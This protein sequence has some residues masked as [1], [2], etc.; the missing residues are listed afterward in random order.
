MTVSGLSRIPYGKEIKIKWWGNPTTKGDKIKKR[1]NHYLPVQTLIEQPFYQYN[2]PADYCQSKDV[3]YDSNNQ[4]LQCAKNRYHGLDCISNA[5]KT[6]VVQSGCIT[7]GHNTK[8]QRYR[9]YTHSNPRNL[10]LQHLVS[11][12][13]LNFNCF[14]FIHILSPT[15]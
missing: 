2:Q 4:V 12:H 5:R 10:H 13:L 6:G 3:W 11:G 1:Q 14:V 7:N 15:Y 8:H 9:N